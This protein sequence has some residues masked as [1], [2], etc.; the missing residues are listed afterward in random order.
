MMRCHPILPARLRAAL[1]RVERSL[2]GDA[3]GA[4]ALAFL[5][6]LSLFIGD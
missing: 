3:F 6:F 1:D 4:A 2:L 5:L